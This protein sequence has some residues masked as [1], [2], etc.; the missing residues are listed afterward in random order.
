MRLIIIIFIACIAC[1]SPEKDLE[2]EFSPVKVVGK[3]PIYREGR[4]PGCRV[5]WLVEKKQIYV[6]SF[7]P[8]S[9]DQFVLG[10]HSMM[11]I[12]R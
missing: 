3:D 6:S 11:L 1:C 7:E 12:Q 5:I 10:T 8:C 9:C 2:V 4:G